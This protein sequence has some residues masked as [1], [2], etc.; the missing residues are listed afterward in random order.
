MVPVKGV[1]GLLPYIKKT[2]DR[3]EFPPRLFQPSNKPFPSEPLFL[4]DSLDKLFIV[5][6]R[7]FNY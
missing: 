1:N 6:V 7:D 3:N 4:F 5:F 2:L